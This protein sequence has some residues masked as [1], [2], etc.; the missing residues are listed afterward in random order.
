MLKTVH[1]ITEYYLQMQDV[2]TPA[3]QR[4]RSASGQVGPYPSHPHL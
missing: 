1:G 2:G 3:V 4:V